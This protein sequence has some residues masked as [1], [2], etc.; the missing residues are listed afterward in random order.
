M[1]CTHLCLR[2]LARSLQAADANAKPKCILQE[3]TLFVCLFVCLLPCVLQACVKCVKVRG[4]TS[5]A[6]I[7]VAGFVLFCLAFC[8]RMF[9]Q[10]HPSKATMFLQRPHITSFTPPPDKQT[11]TP[12]QQQ[13]VQD[14]AQCS[15]LDGNRMLD[16]L[17]CLFVC[18]L[19]VRGLMLQLLR[20]S[21]DAIPPHARGESSL[22]RTPTTSQHT[23]IND[24]RCIK[25]SCRCVTSAIFNS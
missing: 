20:D 7:E 16:L 14:H 23:L 15:A 19:L 4:R 6:C 5:H 25:I 11:T 12:T 21:R 1:K 13:H 18:L 22:R 8:S 2:A 17:V 3:C 10:L 24:H 9:T